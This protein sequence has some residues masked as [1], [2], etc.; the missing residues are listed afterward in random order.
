MIPSLSSV[1]AKSIEELNNL[2][3]KQTKEIQFLFE[4]NIDADNIRA[5]SITANEIAAGTITADKLNVSQLSAITANLGAVTA[6]TIDG[7]T[8]TGGTVRTASSGARIE[9]SSNKLRAYDTSNN[10]TAKIDATSV[11]P[12]FT[13][14]SVQIVSD[15]YTGVEHSIYFGGGSTYA[16]VS[17]GGT[18][19]SNEL[20]VWDNNRV[21]ITAGTSPSASIT[22]TS[23]SVA[24]N[25]LSASLAWSS[26]T[27]T[28]TTLGGYGISSVD[29]SVISGKPTTLS[30]YGI[31]DAY[32]KTYTDANFAAKVHTHAIADVTFLQSSLNAKALAGGNTTSTTVTITGGSHNHG[33]ANGTQLAVFGGGYV[34]WSTYGGFSLSDGGHT[35]VQQS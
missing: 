1:D 9:L 19:Y 7:L 3:A 27:G 30:G 2:V 16:K 32:T 25:G 33:I 12:T 26:I 4:G 11:T 34:T 18:A 10:E 13:L 31:T 20:D 8:I 24:I 5:N 14:G 6:G 35:H 29:W 17:R 23:S 22:I 28:P 15:Q 21:K